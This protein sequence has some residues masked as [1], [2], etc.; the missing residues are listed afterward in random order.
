MPIFK[1]K[2]YGLSV[3]VLVSIDLHAGHPLSEQSTLVR[4]SL[5]VLCSMLRKVGAGVYLL[6]MMSICSQLALIILA[7]HFTY[8][9]LTQTTGWQLGR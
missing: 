5:S 9:F 2:E 1:K 3:D 7:L 4:L 6:L 8:L